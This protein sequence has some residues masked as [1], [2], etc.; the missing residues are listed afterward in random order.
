MKKP[1]KKETE[2]TMN[3]MNSIFG[4]Y[5]RKKLR[6]RIARRQKKALDESIELRNFMKMIP[7][8]Y[9]VKINGVTTSY[10][11]PSLALQ[12]KL[13]DE[14]LEELKDLHVSKTEL[15]EMMDLAD[16]ENPPSDDFFPKCAELLQEIEFLMQRAWG[17]TEDAAYHTWWYQ[18]PHCTCPTLDNAE[19]FGVEGKIIRH[20]C[21]LHGKIYEEAEAT[22]ETA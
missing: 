17:F 13:S 14:N 16:P 2:K 12:Q 20:D 10:M 5:D 22:A 21:P 1:E 15:F 11:N 19:R 4:K 18:A 8:K 7:E 3:S 9:H 6:K